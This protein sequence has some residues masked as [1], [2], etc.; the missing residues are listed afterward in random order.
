M[1]KLAFFVS[2]S[3]S[4]MQAIL[5]A[6]RYG[7]I[8]ATP[9]LVVASKSNIKAIDR[10]KAHGIDTIVTADYKKMGYNHTDDYILHELSA[11]HIDIIL[12]AGYLSIISSPIVEAFKHR[13]LNIH[14]SLIPVFCGK[15]YYGMHVHDA[16][17]AS[18]VK[19]TGATVHFV[20]S[21]VDTG[22]IVIQE[23]YYI[24][25]NDTPSDIQKGVLKIEHQIY[26]KAVKALVENRI[27]FVDNRCY[28]VYSS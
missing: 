25:P 19:V 17:Y 16:V 8:A 3:G 20:D 24:Q 7:D 23:V 2:G 5:D 14:P 11:H 27:K 9:A 10:A 1:K 4:N 26:P 6:I 15:G 22:D 21:G 13:I 12:L 28:I 18:G